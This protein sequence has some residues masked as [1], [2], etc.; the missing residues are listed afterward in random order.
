MTVTQVMTAEDLA[1]LDEDGYRFNLIR[2]GLVRMAAAGF[3]HGK[4]ALRLGRFLGAFV[5]E[6]GLG[7]VVGAETGFILARDPDTVLAP[8]AA[9]VRADRLPPEDDQTGFLSLAPDLVIEVVSPSDRAGKVRAKVQEYLAAGVPLVWLL[10]PDQRTVQVSRG[11]GTTT[12]LAEGDTLDGEA[13]L[14][15]FQLP[16]ADLFA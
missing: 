6:R 1:E 16:V 12:T 8:D 4:L 13:V 14:P 9:F 11:D 2:G 7:V 10:R 3:R 5:D 15:G